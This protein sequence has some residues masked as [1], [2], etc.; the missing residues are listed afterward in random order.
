LSTACGECIDLWS[1]LDVGGK[2]ASY[3][4]VNKI[5]A[6]FFVFFGDLSVAASENDL[7]KFAALGY[8]AGCRDKG[9]YIDAAVKNFDVG[10]SALQLTAGAE[11]VEQRDNGGVFSGTAGKQLGGIIEGISLDAYIYYIGGVVV[12]FSG[13]C[14]D[15]Y[16]YV[17]FYTGLEAKALFLDGSKVCASCYHGDI[18]SRGSEKSCDRTA[19]AAGSYDKIL[20]KNNSFIYRL[21][22]FFYALKNIICDSVVGAAF[23]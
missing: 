11:D 5:G 1:A 23:V 22:F 2:I 16:A 21:K 8:L 15:F 14:L 13:T 19:Y 4:G 6:D 3:T 9:G 10:K 18:L 17:A 20:H 12:V 7:E